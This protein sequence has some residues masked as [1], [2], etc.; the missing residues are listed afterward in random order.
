MASVKMDLVSYLIDAIRQSPLYSRSMKW[1]SGILILSLTV[2][3]L[4][5]EY[6]VS[7]DW[8]VTPLGVDLPQMALRQPPADRELKS[9]HQKF[10]IE[11]KGLTLYEGGEPRCLI[12]QPASLEG[13]EKSAIALLNSVL[14]KIAGKPLPVVSE[15][16][17][18]IVNGTVRDTKKQSW[19]SV[20]WIGHTK[21][22]AERGITADDLEAEGY[23]LKTVDGW[24]FSVGHD[25]HS[26]GAYG[27]LYAAIAILEDY[28]GVRWLWPG[29]LGT[30]IPERR[31]LILPAIHEQNEPA[32]RKRGIRSRQGITDTDEIGLK[33]MGNTEEQRQAYEQAM[34][35]KVEW[36]RLSRIGG[37][38]RPSAGHSYM[39]WFKKYGK[40]HPEWFALQADGNR[41]VQRLDRPR[42]CKSNPAVAAQKAK[43]VIAQFQKSPG[44]DVASISP[45]DG[46]GQDSFCMCAECRKLDPP[47]G[48]PIVLGFTK[49]G[50]R[51]Y[52]ECVSLSD[53]MAIFYNRIA[54]DVIKV[55]PNARLGA[56]AYSA[57]RDVPTRT[58]LHP[59]IIVGFVGLNYFDENLRQE[60]IKRWDGWSRRASQL[61][62]RPNITGPGNLLPAVFVTR[63]AQDIRYMYR[64]GM[65]A[66]DFD[67]LT[68]SWSTVG[69]NYYVLAKLLWDPTEDVDALMR[70]YCEAGF[71]T[72]SHQ[73]LS[74]FEELDK[75]V[76]TIAAN[77]VAEQRE[78]LR[79]EDEDISIPRKQ[80]DA[81]VFSNAYFSVFTAEYVEHLRK[82]LQEAAQSTDEDRVKVRIAFLARGLDY[83][84]LVRA[85]VESKDATNSKQAYKA[86]LDWYRKTLV[87]EPRAIEIVPRLFRTKSSFRGVDK[88]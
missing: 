61:F 52:H 17:I 83:A 34:K 9:L 51:S 35:E 14:E 49:E 70:D 40:E 55:V 38:F 48:N 30:V 8:A 85:T 54:E 24:L 4:A 60:D 29:E 71:G 37:T 77:K 82:T 19:S 16:K 3:A 7:N 81:D 56:Y 57:Y 45:N 11:G 68:G 22:A 31:D 39:D 75:A 59:S 46:S 67:S 27:N 25:M 76:D 26:G 50:K 41:E 65:V 32:L 2:S 21:Q 87:E 53:R 23:R 20:I 28:L 36:A 10:P 88:G 58:T 74:Y 66:T 72:A 80:V 44:L 73:I 47:E 84:D 43:E 86:L 15:A 18:E 62:L 63:M 1:L 12:V 69:I 6:V 79:K 5:E 33:V 64:T 42:L 78:E 13:G